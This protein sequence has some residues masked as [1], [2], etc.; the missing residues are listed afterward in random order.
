[1]RDGR[2]SGVNMY[3]HP[4]TEA[5]WQ[6]QEVIEQHTCSFNILNLCFIFLLLPALS[7]F[8]IALTSLIWTRAVHQLFQDNL[9][10]PIR[11]RHAKQ[12]VRLNP[13]VCARIKH[14]RPPKLIVNEIQLMSPATRCA[15]PSQKRSRCH[16]SGRKC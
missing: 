4:S 16:Y 13:P 15:D 6:C 5:S 9:L 12:R 3:I 11:A 8:H 2:V 7:T 1:M 10:L 14:S